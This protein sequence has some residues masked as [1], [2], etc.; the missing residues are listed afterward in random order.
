MIC[1]SVL[2]I[3]HWIDQGHYSSF[4]SSLNLTFR[5]VINNGWCLSRSLTAVASWGATSRIISLWR[6]NSSIKF[7][8]HTWVMNGIILPMSSKQMWVK[9]R[10]FLP[11]LAYQPPFICM[12]FWGTRSWKL[13]FEDRSIDQL[14]IKCQST[15]KTAYLLDPNILMTDPMHFSDWSF[16]NVMEA[17]QNYNQSNELKTVIRF[18][19]L[20]TTGTRKISCGK[21]GK[22]LCWGFTPFSWVTIHLKY[23]HRNFTILISDW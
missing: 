11:Q 16:E 5:K 7:I 19:Y 14:N 12:Y 6:R 13:N 8:T 23:W 22:M 17:K 4:C 20:Q 9:N 18:S 10:H 21:I 1:W 2:Y 15:V 3:I